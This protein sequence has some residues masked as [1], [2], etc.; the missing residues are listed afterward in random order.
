MGITD[1]A[2]EKQMRILGIIWRAL[3]DNDK[4]DYVKEMK[5]FIT[6]EVVSNSVIKEIQKLYEIEGPKQGASWRHR[7]GA[8][9][10]VL[11]NGIREEDFVHVVAY[12]HKDDTSNNSHTTNG[13]VV[14]VRPFSEFKNRFAF[15]ELAPSSL[16]LPA[17]INN[18]DTIRLRE[19]KKRLMSIRDAG[20]TAPSVYD[21]NNVLDMLSDIPTK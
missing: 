9:V 21:I 6:N 4:F 14:W 7:S 16:L 13:R 3:R 1:D 19:V 8:D 20:F 5:D 15:V 18:H 12:S 17:V 10:I 2:S 11:F